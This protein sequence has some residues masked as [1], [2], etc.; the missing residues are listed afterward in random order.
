MLQESAYYFECVA[1]DLFDFYDNKAHTKVKQY[2]Q[3][4]NMIA[5][6][7]LNKFVSLLYIA[8]ASVLYVCF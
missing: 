6:K 5:T 4:A 3:C 2:C 1:N 8:P 7:H